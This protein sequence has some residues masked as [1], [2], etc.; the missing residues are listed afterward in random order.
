MRIERYRLISGAKRARGLAVIIDVFR[1]FTTAAHVM[2]NGAKR[3]FPVARLERAL[4]LKRLH[5]D[6][7]LIGERGG[8]RLEGF[9]FGNSP[10]E[11]RD[12]DFTGKTV[13]QTTGSGT[14][15]LVNARRA[16]EIVLGTFVTAGAIVKYVLRAQPELVSLVSM[17][18]RGVEPCE[19]DEL[20]A[21][22]IEGALEGRTLD[23]EEIE[24]RIRKSPSGAKFFDPSQSQ[25]H[26]ED[27]YMALDLDRF[28]FI[29]RAVKE[30]GLYI[31]KEQC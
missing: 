22:Y 9:D 14:Q 5:S 1:A 3:I 23:S 20:C 13:I 15:G 18:S 11:V 19:E 17:G 25:F 21:D 2:A 4:E 10:L 24:R 26:R 31:V 12:V 7:V 6:W 29:L 28:D 8:R 16:D 27:F 30:D